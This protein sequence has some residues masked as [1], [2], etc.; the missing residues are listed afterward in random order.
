MYARLLMSP[1]TFQST[2]QNVTLNIRKKGYCSSLVV[3]AVHVFVVV[4]AF[5]CFFDKGRG[6]RKKPC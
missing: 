1:K 5:H 3:V 6:L 2:M 4:K